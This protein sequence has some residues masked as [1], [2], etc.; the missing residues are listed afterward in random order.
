MQADS[1]KSYSLEIYKAFAAKRRA[2]KRCK[3][4]NE[5]YFPK[6]KYDKS[7]RDCNSLIL[8]YEKQRELEVLERSN[9]GAFYCYNKKAHLTQR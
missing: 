2:W 8:Q 3:C 5:N 6:S 4:D 9:L 1:G 7:T